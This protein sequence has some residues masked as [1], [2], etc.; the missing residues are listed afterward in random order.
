M[1]R[2]QNDLL[3][4]FDLDTMPDM[5]GEATQTLFFFPDCG[6]LYSDSAFVPKIY[7][8]YLV[9]LLH[10]AT[11]MRYSWHLSC[12]YNSRFYERGTV[13]PNITGRNIFI[14]YIYIYIYS[15]IYIYTYSYIYI[16]SYIV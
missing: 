16:Y 1:A 13:Y 8:L 4:G 9:I 5:V 12:V 6:W 3:P 2:N 10:Y 15:C 11:N 7:L 14:S